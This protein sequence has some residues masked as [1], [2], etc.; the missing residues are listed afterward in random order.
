VAPPVFVLDAG[1]VEE[2][3]RV[4]ETNC[5]NSTGFYW[6]DLHAVVCAVNAHIRLA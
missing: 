2:G 3:L 6:C 4:V 5:F 1:E